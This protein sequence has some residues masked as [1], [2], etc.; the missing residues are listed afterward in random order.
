MCECVYMC[1]WGILRLVSYCCL[2]NYPKFS[3]FKAKVYDL[4]L[5][6]GGS[7]GVSHKAAV[8][9]LSQGYSSLKVPLGLET[10]EL[11]CSFM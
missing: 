6:L 10:L 8:K 5:F 11:F 1:V 3:S 9:L 2:T 4:T 7:N